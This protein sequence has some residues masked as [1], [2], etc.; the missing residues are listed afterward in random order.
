MSIWNQEN[1]IKAW[2]YACSAHNGQ[3]VP[4]TDIPYI[5]HI[6]LVAM[7]AMAAITCSSTIN[8]PDLLVL[9]AL[10]HDTLEDAICTYDE[11]HKRFGPEVANGVLALSK[12][13]KLTSKVRQMRD[14]I[15]RIKK[16][17][18]EVWMVKLADRIT[19]L[20][21]PPEHWD[22]EKITNYR[23]EAVIILEELGCANSYLAERLKVK[24]NN[25]P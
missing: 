13:K 17:P 21:P 19:N 14:S 4:S 15:N 8:A 16:E 11:I 5:N 22:A 9:C 20:Q 2:N 12:N 24:I 3:F 25:Y 23:S 7:E 10:L 6:G 18:Q 1:Y